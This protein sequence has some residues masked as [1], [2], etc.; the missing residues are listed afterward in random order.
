MSSD[1]KGNRVIVLGAGFSCSAGIPLQKD[2]LT[3][4]SQI[5]LDL[6]S[7]GGALA[8]DK[9]KLDAFLENL[10]GLERNPENITLEDLYTMI[11]MAIS[12]QRNI[13]IFAPSSLFKIRESLDRLIL[14]TVNKDIP[15][16]T[17]DD[18]KVKVEETIGEKNA[19]FINLNWDFLLEQILL[20]LGYQVEYGVSLK[21][22]EKHQ[23]RGAA[24]KKMLVLKPHGSLNWR[25]C[26]ICE[27]IY[28]FMKYSDISTCSQCRSIYEKKN[29]IIQLF[30]DKHRFTFEPD[31]LPLLVSPTFMK[32]NIVPQLNI[33]MQ[34]MYR[35]L[36]EADELIFIGYSL[37][38]SD[39][40]IRDYLIKAYSLKPEISVKVILKSNDQREKKALQSHYDSIFASAEPN[41][42]WDG[43]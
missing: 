24:G 26:P 19:V 13:G 42:H 29:R 3:D 15:P 2:L 36:T 37:P 39:H 22:I 31:L 33:I 8:R 32:N 12:R 34:K 40:D 27:T 7:S 21:S 4:I 35:A 20:H 38:I 14:Y 1:Q 18:Y 41:Y 25:L 43:F 28:F 16:E 23:E 6:F 11:D 5:E 9:Q 17:I 10:Y 30:Q